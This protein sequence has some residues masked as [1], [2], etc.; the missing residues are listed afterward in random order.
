VIKERYLKEQDYVKMLQIYDS[1]LKTPGERRTIGPDVIDDSIREG[2]KTGLFGLGE[3]QGDGTVVCRFFKEDPLIASTETEVL[4]RDSVCVAQR[5]ALT[6]GGVAVT[7]AQPEAE[8]QW[9]KPS[10]VGVKLLK[11]LE[12][13]FKIPR[14]KI[15]Q[16]MGVM[17]YLL[18]KFQS[19]EMEI[20]AEDGSLS[21]DEY[22]NKIKE[23]LRQLGIEIEEE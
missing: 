23:A 20:R 16:L 14:G 9:T 13:K 1:M 5:Q 11:E 12:L 10:Q 22:S 17:N 19:L 18:S 15:A 21:E 3:L 6:T 8:V 2:V 4:L 7:I